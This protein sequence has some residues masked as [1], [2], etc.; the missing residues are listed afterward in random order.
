MKI[1]RMDLADTGSPMGLVT[2]ILSVERDLP[3]P[4]PIEELARQL[5]IERIAPLETEGFEGGLVTDDA[6]STGF[7]LV[8]RAAPSGR[9]RFTI[10][11]ELGHFLIVSHQPVEAGKFLCSRADMAKWSTEQGDRYARMEAEANEFAGLLLIPKPALQK[12]IPRGDPTLAHIPLVAKHFDVSKEAAARAYARYH[13]EQLAIVVVKDGI[14]RR[15]HK[16]STFP[17]ISVP[18]GKPVPRASSFH[19]KDLRQRVAS[20]LSSIIPEHWVE[21]KPGQRAELFEQ[22][23]PQ[24]DGFALLML[25]LE[26][27]EAE[28]VDDDRTSAQRFR[29]QQSRWR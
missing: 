16:G 21:L 27:E 22:V 25:W 4:V 13:P 7:I 23:Y 29:D 15:A 11:H 18:Y 6:R 1:S 20:E 17:W 12:F 9:R 5:D 19:R 8:N 2:K 14:V 10:G 28:E 24:Q 3:I 26:V